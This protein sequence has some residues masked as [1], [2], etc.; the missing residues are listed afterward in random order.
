MRSIRRSISSA[1]YRATRISVSK[2]TRV[3]SIADAVGVEKLDDRGPHVMDVAF[4][5]AARV[6]RQPKMERKGLAQVVAV[7]GIA[8][9]E[10]RDRLRL[11]LFDNL[12]VA[13]PSGR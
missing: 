13:R 10:I 1:P 3:K 12:E 7:L 6:E 5:A 11:A 2:S 8:L 9:G 4:H